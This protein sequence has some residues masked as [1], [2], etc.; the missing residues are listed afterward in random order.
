VTIRGY[1]KNLR[2]RLKRMKRESVGCEPNHYPDLGEGCKA[3]PQTRVRTA[4]HPHRASCRALPARLRRYPAGLQTGSPVLGRVTLRHG[5][6]PRHSSRPSSSA[7]TRS[8]KAALIEAGAEEWSIYTRAELQTLCVQ[9][10]VAPLTQAEL[11]KLTKSSEPLTLGSPRT[12]DQLPK[13]FGSKRRRELQNAISAC[14]L[15]TG[16][17]MAIL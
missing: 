9:N 17:I 3:W 10:R 1:L 13:R 14:S 4:G 5:C 11:A 7:R 15:R 12:T 16:L 6:T 8:T 2:R